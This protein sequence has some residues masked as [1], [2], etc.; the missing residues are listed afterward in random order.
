MGEYKKVPDLTKNMKPVW[1]NT[2]E[3]EVFLFY[4]GINEMC[5]T[6]SM[7][8]NVSSSQRIWLL[9]MNILDMECLSSGLNSFFM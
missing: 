8:G 3:S 1:E 9:F 4:A 6:C 2:K 7:K 5:Q